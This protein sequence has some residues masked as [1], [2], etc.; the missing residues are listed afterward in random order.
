MV[1]S[2]IFRS[3]PF[4]RRDFHCSKYLP[5]MHPT[6]GCW[7]SFCAP[8]RWH[9]AGWTQPIETSQL[10]KLP[11]CIVPGSPAGDPIAYSPA[12]LSRAANRSQPRKGH[13]SHHI[14][15]C[16]SFLFS[17]LLLLL[18]QPTRHYKITKKWLSLCICLQLSL[19][20]AVVQ[21]SAQKWL[22]NK[23]E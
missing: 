9:R 13:M 1:T 16:T 5:K 4:T 11:R 10:A 17:N 23:D 15:C 19:H 18:L 12:S 20:W 8:R 14:S 22:Q 7:G 6:P 2:E 21:V 3:A